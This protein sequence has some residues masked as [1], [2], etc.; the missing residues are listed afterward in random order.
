[1]YESKLAEIRW[2]LKAEKHENIN[3]IANFIQDHV[4]RWFGDVHPLYT[5]LN[6]LLAEE[7]SELDL[8]YA[9]ALKYANASLDM[10]QAIFGGNCEQI[11]KDYFLIGKIHFLNA[12]PH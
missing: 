1:M 12:K 6:R 4:K 8:Q 2:Y 5:H 3:K 10:Q 7:Y 9:K 11:W